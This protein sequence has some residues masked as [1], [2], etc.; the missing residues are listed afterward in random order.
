MPEDERLEGQVSE[1]ISSEES[2]GFDAFMAQGDEARNREEKKD[3]KPPEKKEEEKASDE[4]KKQEEEKKPDEKKEEK[5]E[6]KKPGDE[7]EKKDEDDPEKE[8]RER[9]EKKAEE[10]EAEEFEEE[11]ETPKKKEEKAKGDEEKDDHVTKER[12]IN[13]LKY[14]NDDD[15]PKGEFVIG[16]DTVN[17]E[18]LKADDPEVWNATK[19]IAYAVAEKMVAET[20]KNS[21]LASNE[22]LIGVQKEIVELRFWTDVHEV[23]PDGRKINNSDE[24]KDWLKGQKPSIRRIAKGAEVEDACDIITMFKESVAAKNAEEHDDNKRKEANK[25]K[26]LHKGSIRQKKDVSQPGETRE[27]DDETAG[28]NSYFDGKE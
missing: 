27:T 2:E 3:E 16:D 21:G 15:L 4:E 22:Q 26:D 6:E 9:L 10:F 19:V 23:H 18:S 12:L 8:A 1:Q 11:E 20:L 24:F 28:F 25:N 13:I 14:L 17:L 5:K 7:E